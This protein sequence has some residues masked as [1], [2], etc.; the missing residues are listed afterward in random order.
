MTNERPPTILC[1]ASYYK[2][3]LFLR[4]A[5]QLGAHVILITKEKLADEDWPRDSIAEYFT[6]PDPARQ[7]DV[8]HAVSYL[9]RTRVIDAI[10][11]L[12]EYD[13]FTAASLRE[14][15][16]LPGLGE[17]AVR[18]VRDKLAMRIKAR[19]A[20]IA[21]PNFV[22]VLNYD[23]LRAFM[24][25][26]P[27]PWLLKP[28]S[29]AATMGIKQIGQPDD[30]WPWLEKLGDDQS[31][32]LLERYVA[33]NVYH[34]DSI[35]AD[36]KVQFAAVHKYGRPPLDVVHGGGVFTTSTVPAEMP[37][38]KRLLE[39]NEHLIQ[40]FEFAQGVTHAEF[41]HVA[42]TNEVYFLEIAGR[43]GGAYIDQVIEQ[44]NGI[45]LWAEWARVEVSAI[46]REAYR[47]P[48]LL[49]NYSGLV[50][51]LARQ[52]E[53]D[54]S[55]YQ[56]PEITWR[57]KKPHHAGLIVSSPDHARV[58]DLLRSYSERFVTDFLAYQP[59]LDHPPE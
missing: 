1:L 39:Q 9:A 29:E 21:V 37:L 41:I 58:D 2:G 49:H 11:P 20:G 35:V 30:L 45:N 50:L 12:D 57:L 48:Q 10:V 59:P 42:E 47:L 13:A 53:P 55:A 7:P 40:A 36:S 18:Y 14:H 25:Q 56:D 38:A 19:D 5:A 34:V 43:V 32:F 23:Q 31:S 46:R 24:Q 17:S 8:T 51:C 54:L 15:L 4:A 52:E 33:G 27:P 26:V 22:H 3:P 6:M 44:A 28:R 16:R